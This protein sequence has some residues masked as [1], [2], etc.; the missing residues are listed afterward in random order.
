[1]QADRCP[2][3]QTA[4]AARHDRY[5]DIHACRDAGDSEDDDEL[6]DIGSQII[7]SN[8]YTCG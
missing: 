3:R 6:A 8:T 7:L 2:H 4:H 5:T 1:M